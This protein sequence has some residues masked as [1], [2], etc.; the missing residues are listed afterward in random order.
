MLGERLVD[1]LEVT[2]DPVEELADLPLITRKPHRS[3]AWKNFTLVLIAS[4]LATSPAAMP[5]IPSA[6]MYR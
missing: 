5:P 1:L 6:T 3:D 2:V 4:R